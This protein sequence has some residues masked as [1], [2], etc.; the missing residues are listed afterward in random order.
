MTRMTFRE[1][2]LT[3]TSFQSRLLHKD[4]ASICTSQTHAA[5]QSQCSPMQ[6][7]HAEEN[8]IDLIHLT[9]PVRY[10]VIGWLSSGLILQAELQQLLASIKSSSASDR[11]HLLVSY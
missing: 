8:Y 2:H 10:L 9:G 11:T 1:N 5:A 3:K 4:T 6:R 7:V